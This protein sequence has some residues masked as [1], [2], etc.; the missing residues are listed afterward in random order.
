MTKINTIVLKKDVEIKEAK[1]SVGFE[2]VSF[3]TSEFNTEEIVT[4]PFENEISL[5]FIGIPQSKLQELLETGET[6][7]MIV[8]VTYVNHKL[9]SL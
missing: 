9:N 8:E 1:G 5:Y 6:S 7:Y 4:N 3:E 2:P